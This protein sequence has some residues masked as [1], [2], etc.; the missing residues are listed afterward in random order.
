MPLGSSLGLASV[1]NIVQFLTNGAALED[2]AETSYRRRK[3]KEFG[4]LGIVF[5]SSSPPLSVD[6]CLPTM[7]RYVESG[8]EKV[9]IVSDRLASSP[10]PTNKRPLSPTPVDD[11]PA[12]VA[13]SVDNASVEKQPAKR[14]RVVQDA[15]FK[16]RGQ[17]MFG[18]LVGTLN[19]F[20]EEGSKQTDAV[21]LFF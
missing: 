21:S 17:R 10:S 13:P 18:V 8:S 11:A 3:D 14:Q 5:D 16:K 12:V 7:S 6:Y 15:E 9:V 20:R 2:R 4:W 19:K 1:C